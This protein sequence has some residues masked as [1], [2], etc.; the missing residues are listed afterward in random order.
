M[1]YCTQLT[2]RLL[3]AEQVASLTCFANL[4]SGFLLAAAAWKDTP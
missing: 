4:F 3:T 2:Y 1:L